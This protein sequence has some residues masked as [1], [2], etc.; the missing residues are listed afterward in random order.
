MY[1]KMKMPRCMNLITCSFDWNNFHPKMI[2][3]SG[4][5]IRTCLVNLL[6]SCLINSMCPWTE[7]RVLFI[8]KPSK[9]DY[10]DPSAY[11]PICKSSHVGKVIERILN[12]RLKIFLMNSN[13]VDHERQGFLPEKALH[14]HYTNSRL[15]A[16]YLPGTKRK[17]LSITLIL[18]K[19]LIVCGTIGCF[20]NYGQQG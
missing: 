10:T 7:S 14:V 6:T 2:V 20:S 15:N 5:K 13:L 4:P 11:R 9:P 8:R 12:N 3:K 18:K 17:L 19:H 1:G 16:K